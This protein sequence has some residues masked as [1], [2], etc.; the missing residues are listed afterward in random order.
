MLIQQLNSRISHSTFNKHI[1]TLSKKEIINKR[2]VSNSNQIIPSTFI[3]LTTKGK[4]DYN[5][6]I[7]DIQIAT[8][9]NRILYQLL[10]FFECYKRSNILSER[11]FKY[12]LKR[13]GIKF[14]NM[15]Q[16]DIKEL[17]QIKQHFSLNVTISYRTYNNISI[18]EYTE[19][20]NS[21]K[22]YYLVLPGFTIEEFFDYLK[23]L[24]KCNEPHPFSEFSKCLEI[25]YIHFHDFSKKEI[26]DAMQLIRNYDIIKPIADIYPGEMRY[27]I[28]N[29]LLVFTYI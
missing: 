20:S 10:L 29:E 23:L 7:L 9:K 22:C 21:S 28:C 12:F 5:L 27:D 19:S 6:G 24:Q 17:E 26:F 16:M 13:I 2:K 14:E 11:Q 25:P 18:A 3:S 8:N 15:E 1:N 4:N